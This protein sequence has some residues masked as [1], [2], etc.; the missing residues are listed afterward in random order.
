MPGGRLQ[1]YRLGDRSELLVGHLLAGVA[2]TTPVPRQEDIGV[3]YMCSLITSDD[4]N[5]GLLKAGPFFFVQSKSSTEAWTF[6]KPHELEWIKHQE[7]PILL[8][9]ADREAGAMDVY[10]TWNLLCG[11]LNGWKGQKAANCIRLCPGK[12]DSKWPGVEDREDGS[13]DILLG[14]PIIRIS[15]DEIFDK[16]SMKRISGLIDQWISLDRENIVNRQAGMQWVVGPL[17]YETGKSLSPERGVYFAWNPQD[18][19]KCSVNLNRS[20]TA[21]WRVLRHGGSSQ[22]V[23]QAPWNA[24]ITPLRELLRWVLTVDP[25]LRV[26]LQDLDK[27]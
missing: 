20:A 13:Q 18:L 2:F 26:L 7:N 27:N 4:E 15:H 12:S 22:V 14:K 5:A 23:T 10:S 3:D 24:G 17:T 25:L 8:C 16:E 19:A 9:V 6:E 11:A 21:L 1:S